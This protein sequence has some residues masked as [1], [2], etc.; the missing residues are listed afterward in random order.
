[1][2]S[3]FWIKR[4]P[5]C[6]CSF[7]FLGQ[8]TY[9]YMYR[10]FI[11]TVKP[12]ICWEKPVIKMPG[13]KRHHEMRPV[14]WFS[15]AERLSGQIIARIVWGGGYSIRF[16]TL[17][18][19]YFLWNMCWVVS[20]PSPLMFTIIRFVVQSLGLDEKFSCHRDFLEKFTL[21]VNCAFHSCTL[22]I[23]CS[24]LCQEAESRGENYDRVK[25]LEI[26]AEDADKLERKRKKKNPDQGFSGT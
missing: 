5:A 19:F 11:C 10:Y 22:L 20:L 4:V 13:C 16:Y 18:L 3:R 14:K 15:N 12:V 21:L 7:A 9:M 17:W 23:F 2:Y 8:D 24:K 1:M 6:H 26:T 25:M